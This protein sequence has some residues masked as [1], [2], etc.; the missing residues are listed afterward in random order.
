[1][2][3]DDKRSRNGKVRPS[4]RTD[5]YPDAARSPGQKRKSQECCG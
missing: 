1:M 3:P 5:N 2:H 4:K